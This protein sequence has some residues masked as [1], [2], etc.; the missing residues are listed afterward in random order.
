MAN[1]K[2]TGAFAVT[3]EDFYGTWTDSHGFTHTISADT[4]E[5]SKKSKPMYKFSGLK[6]T[7][8]EDE[9]GRYPFGF[10][11]VSKAESKIIGTCQA[12]DEVQHRF[13]LDKSKEAMK[14][15]SGY[16]IDMTAKRAEVVQKADDEKKA[17]KQEEKA[18]K[19]EPGISFKYI[20]CPTNALEIKDLQGMLEHKG[21]LFL[22]QE[23]FVSVWDAADPENLK[24]VSEF[25]FPQRRNNMRLFGDELYVWGKWI[26]ENE[27]H[28]HIL[29][30]SDPAHIAQKQEITLQD[31]NVEINGLYVTNGRIF[32]AGYEGGIMEI[33]RDGTVKPLFACERGISD[34]L[35]YESLL[36]TKG[37]STGFDGVCLFELGEPLTEIKDIPAQFVIPSKLAWWEEGKSILILG[38]DESV[39]K[40]DVSDPAN[41]KRVKSAKTGLGLSGRFARD[42]DTIFVLGTAIRSKN[43]MP[44]V[45]MIDVSGEIPELTYKQIIKEYKEKSIGH[46]APRGIV[47][48]GDYLILAT[49]K[50]ELGVVK[51]VK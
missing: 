34:V 12:G 48:S 31:G 47:K 26:Y 32:A 13:Y 29:D 19:P 3:Q 1:S 23:L 14:I 25:Q 21:Y 20:D 49:Y 30:V 9:K 15:V 7:A 16:F 35:V 17:K 4:Y 33:L 18:Q 27:S 46:D 28:I 8:L 51:I 39:I 24:K 42:G 44:A 43:H 11:T 37:G 5:L 10:S 36:I 2:T 6:W 22:I 40:M 50:C 45:C 41:A 38:G